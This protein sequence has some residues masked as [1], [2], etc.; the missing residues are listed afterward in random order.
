MNHPRPTRRRWLKVKLLGL[1]IEAEG[2][3][4]LYIAVAIVALAMIVTIFLGLCLNTLSMCR[5]GNLSPRLRNIGPLALV[6]CT[7]L[8]QL[9][10]T[11][12]KL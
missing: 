5:P 9:R 1:S 11:T 3:H 6:A 2:L 4:G 8:K 10:S 7:V 12:N